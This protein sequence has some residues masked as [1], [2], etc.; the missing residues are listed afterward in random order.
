VQKFEGWEGLNT[1]TGASEFSTG[2]ADYS[3]PAANWQRL[4]NTQAALQA[5]GKGQ[6]PL[7]GP[8]FYAEHIAHIRQYL[9]VVTETPDCDQE[10][11][12]YLEQL[13]EDY[14]Y[15]RNFPLNVYL[16]ACTKL[17]GA[18]EDYDLQC[19][20]SALCIGGV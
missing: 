3:D 19:S 8:D 6:A 20:L 12:P 5:I 4:V 9:I 17:M 16:I 7:P 1:S 14:Y 10:V 2:M 11:V 18:K 15:K 13:L